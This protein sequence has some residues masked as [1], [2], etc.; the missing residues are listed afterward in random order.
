[1]SSS[2]KT[3]P[4]DP[5]PSPDRERWIVPLEPLRDMRLGVG[6]DFAHPSSTVL[7]A[8]SG[9]GRRGGT[10]FF[11]FAGVTHRLPVKRLFVRDLQRFWYQRGIAGF[12]GSIDEV[13]GSLR[14]LLDHHGV[15]RVIAMGHSAGGYAALLFGTLL[16]ADVVLSFAPQTVLDRAWLHS[17]GDRRW[18]RFLDP[19]DRAG[20]PDQRYIDL[21]DALPRE[22]SHD[23]LYHV[24]Y[25]GS[26][27]VDESHARHLEGVPGLELHAHAHQGHG[28]VRVLRG[29]GELERIIQAAIEPAGTPQPGPLDERA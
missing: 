23:T 8:F 10:P 21:S 11:E 19:L 27:E 12:G 26:Y 14:E 28:V 1:M 22:H 6:R 13:A 24:H 20:G 9:F 3:E 4:H 5:A 16:E 2:R 18:D 25:N 29:S 17:I 15:E 7:V